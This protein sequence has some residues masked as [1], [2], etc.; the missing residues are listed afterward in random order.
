MKYITRH[1]IPMYHNMTQNW[2]PIVGF[3]IISNDSIST[4]KAENDINNS[5]LEEKEEN[6]NFV[7]LE[8]VVSATSFVYEF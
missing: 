2:P 7:H 5:F 1:Y 6:D 3:K 8:Q 4:E